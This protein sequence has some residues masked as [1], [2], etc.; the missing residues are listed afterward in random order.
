MM[1]IEELRELTQ[2]ELQAVLDYEELSDE[3]MDIVEELIT[4]RY[5]ISKP[6]ENQKK[7]AQLSVKRVDGETEEQAVAR[8]FFKPE[9]QSG[10]A[11]YLAKKGEF[12][13]DDI[14]INSLVGEL[15]RQ[16]DLIKK[17]DLSRAEEMLASQAHT[18]DQLLGV[19][20]QRATANMGEYMDSMETY[21]KLALKAQ[22]QCKNTWEALARIQNP[23]NYV[24]QQNI[25]QNQQINNAPNQ[26][27]G[28]EHEL[29]PDKSHE[30]A[31]IPIDP[32]VETVGE[33]HRAE[34][35]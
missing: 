2:E 20:L 9:L 4:E 28:D 13:G 7:L 10:L 1:T 18:L 14:D 32:P 16:T 26:L 12:L 24:T 3:Q 8:H 30:G 6:E 33:V 25:A 29:L 22:A 27:S 17:K 34:D 5:G 15:E 21:F 19:L 11:T 31:A 35:T 23:P